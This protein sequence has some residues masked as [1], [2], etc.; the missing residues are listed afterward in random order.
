MSDVK[1]RR[2]GRFKV[3]VAMVVVGGL[4]PFLV[5]GYFLSQCFLS[6]SDPSEPWGAR[7]FP[8][9]I[10]SLQEIRASGIGQSSKGTSELASDFVQINHVG[11]ANLMNTG[12]VEI[13]VSLFGL[14]RRKKWAWYLLLA[15]FLWTGLND[16]AA[17][18]FAGMP[19]IP[20]TPTLLAVG[21][22]LLSRRSVFIATASGA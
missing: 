18:W 21:G 10:Y 5:G 12:L 19:P 2:S 3:G 6:V 22:L 17:A 16:A 20:L 15:V 7:Q 4:F 8:S 14:L 9:A 1:G 11:Y 13:V